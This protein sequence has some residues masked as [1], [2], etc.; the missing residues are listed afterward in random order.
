MAPPARHRHP[1]LARIH[2]FVDRHLADPRLS[3]DLIATAHNIS[4]R[5][6]YRLF[7]A[8]NTTV[9]RLIH[10]RRLERCRD[11]LTDPAKRDRPIHAIAARWGFGT[12]AHFTR[13]FRTAY[14]LSPREYR[15]RHGRWPAT[16]A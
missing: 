6:L 14:G 12:A 5:S 11:D 15:R 9:A 3:P 2:A 10:D 16:E 13:A 8:E 1:L 4:S 7:Q